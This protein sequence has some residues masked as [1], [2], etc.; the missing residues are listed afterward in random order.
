MLN[1]KIDNTIVKY[2]EY[3]RKNIIMAYS[4][5]VIIIREYYIQLMTINLRIQVKFTDF[6]R[7]QLAK[8]W[9][10]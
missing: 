1:N 8:A 5:I 3:Y 4:D 7:A 10:R 6:L 9:M 2:Q